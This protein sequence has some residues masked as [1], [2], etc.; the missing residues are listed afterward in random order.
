MPWPLKYALPIQIDEVAIRYPRL[1][2]IIAHLGHPWVADTVVVV[3]KHRTVYSD[4]SGLLGRPWQFYNALLTVVEYGI[5][6][7]ILFGSD[8]P[9]FTPEQ[10]RDALLKINDVVRGTELPRIPT[11]LLQ[12]IID[13]DSLA[14][15]GL[16]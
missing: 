1:K 3:R 11:A 14:L 2:I 12:E 4:I 5:G 15:L 7:K 10:T 6:D 9:F 13:R 16:A 8:F